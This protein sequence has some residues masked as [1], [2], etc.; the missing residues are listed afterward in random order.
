MKAS[1]KMYPDK[2]YVMSGKNYI[3]VGC[4]QVFCFP[5][6][7]KRLVKAWDISPQGPVFDKES[8]VG[9]LNNPLNITDLGIPLADFKLLCMILN[10]NEHGSIKNLT[11]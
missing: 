1:K 9:T 8:S 5:T 4:R 3:E 6:V 10:D 2:V 7:R 11:K